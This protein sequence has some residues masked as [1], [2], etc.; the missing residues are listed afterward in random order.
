MG[1]ALVGFNII[2]MFPSLLML[3][4][5]LIPGKTLGYQYIQHPTCRTLDEMPGQRDYLRSNFEDLG[6]ITVDDMVI[7]QLC[8]LPVSSHFYTGCRYMNPDTYEHRSTNVPSNKTFLQR[9]LPIVKN[10]EWT[11]NFHTQNENV[12]SCPVRYGYLIETLLTAIIDESKWVLSIWRQDYEISR[13]FRKLLK[14][15]NTYVKAEERLIREAFD[16]V[17]ESSSVNVFHLFQLH[18]RNPSKDS[19]MLLKMVLA[20]Y[21][22]QYLTTDRVSCFLHK[23]ASNKF[24][25]FTQQPGQDVFNIQNSAVETIIQTTNDVIEKH[26]PL[27]YIDLAH[28]F[29]EELDHLNIHEII[30]T[31]YKNFLTIQRWMK[32]IDWDDELKRITNASAPLDDVFRALICVND[33]N[34][35]SS[36]IVSQILANLQ[37]ESSNDRLD[38]SIKEILHIVPAV[39]MKLK[40]E[41]LGWL[42]WDLYEKWTGPFL[43][44]TYIKSNR[45]ALG[46]LLNFE[47]QASDVEYTIGATPLY[48]VETAEDRVPTQYLSDQLFKGISLTEKEKE[49]IQ[50]PIK[51]FGQ[52]IGCLYCKIILKSLNLES[53]GRCDPSM[54]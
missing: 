27:P 4:L 48:V 44:T 25:D 35:G 29:V 26:G 1:S 33:G 19:K 39:F 50:Q 5:T 9:I 41:K 2:S 46:N 45:G 30:N 20:K 37:S 18:L 38:Y 10:V 17:F 53:S 12:R 52:Y 32:S 36:K 43:I 31:Q 24:L 34:L 28:A 21:I 14:S 49:I 11:F 40:S 3:L 51:E 47:I 6:K 7:A 22:S 16:T 15:L 8:D 13:I 23:L 42:D 54:C